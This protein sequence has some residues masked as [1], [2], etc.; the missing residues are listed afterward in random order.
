MFDIQ[1]HILE[2]TTSQTAELSKATIFQT[3]EL[4]KATDSQTKKL[5]KVTAEAGS[6]QA[7]ANKSATEAQTMELEKQRQIVTSFTVLTTVFLPLGFCTSV[8]FRNGPDSSR[9][10]LTDSVVLG[11]VCWGDEY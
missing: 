9:G 8:G 5:S 7:D 3:A 6:E 4:S 11:I 10:R 1:T 2:A